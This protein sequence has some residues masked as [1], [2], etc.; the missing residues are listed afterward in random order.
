MPL[1]VT[2]DG[3]PAA[4]ASS[5]T[6]PN[7]SRMAGR[8]GQQCTRRTRHQRRHFFAI[9][10]KRHRPL[11]VRAVRAFAQAGAI[12]AVSWGAPIR[13]CRRPRRASPRP[14]ATAG[15]AIASSRRSRSFVRNDLADEYDT[16]WNAFR[17]G[18]GRSGAGEAWRSES[19]PP[20]RAA[21]P[22]RNSSPRVNSE[23]H[24]N[25][26]DQGIHSPPPEKTIKLPSIG[27]LP[28]FAMTVVPR[29][30]QPE[31]APVR[32][33]RCQEVGMNTCVCTN[34]LATRA[35]GVR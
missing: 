14:R 6:R 13:P 22:W 16:P 35:A 21:I 9:A 26:F 3:R 32:P 4:F 33:Y 25:T 15:I 1:C 8:L 20:S 29:G 24:T 30:A 31:K 27:A 17:T 7:A 23:L 10:E 19:S 2:I 28:S 12:T 34:P 5:T 11:E 18:G